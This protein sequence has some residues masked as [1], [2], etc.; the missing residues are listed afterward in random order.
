M[1]TRSKDGTFKPKALATQLTHDQS[2]SGH[3]TSAISPVK[4]AK[5]TKTTSVSK[6]YYTITEPP[7]YRIAAQYP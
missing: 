5:S 7:S 1:I 3:S 2:L 4:A 6:I